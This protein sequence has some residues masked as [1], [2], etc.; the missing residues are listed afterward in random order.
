MAGIQHGQFRN[1]QL[2]LPVLPTGLVV[3]TLIVVNRCRITK[4]VVGCHSGACWLLAFEFC[5]A[6]W[7]YLLATH[8]DGPFVLQVCF[9]PLR[10]KQW[11]GR[12]CSGRVQQC[13]N[14]S[15]PRLPLHCAPHVNSSP[16]PVPY[17]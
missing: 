5:C 8:L 9:G 10:P 4:T 7:T 2:A 11:G 17:P 13:Q 3:F 16:C 15:S 6:S 1:T 12:A 14:S